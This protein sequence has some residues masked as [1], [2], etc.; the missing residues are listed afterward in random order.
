MR[1]ADHP[2]FYRLPP[3]DGRSRESSI[4][5][6][7]QGRFWHDGELIEHP[8]MVRAFATWIARH[9]DDH[10]YILDNGY[11]WTYLTV[12]DAPFLVRSVRREGRR[13]LLELSDGTEEPLDP[14]LLELGA[15]DALYVHVKGAA[16][17]A[18]FTPFAQTQLSDWLV[19]G[20]DSTVEIE[21]DGTRHKIH[22]RPVRA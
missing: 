9:P 21:I 14:T 7:G 18:R 8:A 1:P 2:E 3:P 13:P 10:R 4:V 12:E 15:A 17:R 16:F 20:S 11:D 5:L 6:D 22:R 19:E